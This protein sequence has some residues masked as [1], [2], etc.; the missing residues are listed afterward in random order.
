MSPYRHGKVKLNLNHFHFPIL[1]VLNFAGLWSRV[2][3]DWKHIAK[4][5]ALLSY[6]PFISR[7]ENPAKYCLAKIAKLSTNEV[8]KARFKRRATAA[9]N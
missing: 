6:F 9:Q 3:R 4:F 2:F 8:F 1:L 5:N 7:K